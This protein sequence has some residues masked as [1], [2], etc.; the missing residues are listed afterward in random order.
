MVYW[1]RLGSHPATILFKYLGQSLETLW[2]LF[3]DRPRAVFV[4][5]PPV[6]AV[7]PV[8][9]YCRLMNVPFVIDAHS[10]AYLNR[11]WRRFQWLQRAMSRAAATTIVTNDV[12][13]DRLRQ[14]GVDVTLV[15]DVPVVFPA[16]P[17]YALTPDF[18]VAVV[19]SF[20]YDEPIEEILEAARELPDVR[21]YMTGNPRALD[22]ALRP[23]L[24][25]NVTLTGFLSTEQY[26][27]LL[28][29]ADVVVTLTTLDHTMLRGAYEAI[30]QGTPVVISDWNILRDSFPQGA[31]HVQNTR[32][33]IRAAIEDVRRDYPRHAEA[34]AGRPPRAETPDVEGH[35]DPP[36]CQR[37]AGGHCGTPAGLN[38]PPAMRSWTKFFLA[39][40]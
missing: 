2:L 24:P 31:S 4:M 13:A 23:R 27:A 3:R 7:L 19:C 5:A 16:A 38:T 9:L 17:P 22:P 10:G 14:D 26:G 11:R 36:S 18:S 28:R 39:G 20:N 25:A 12:L 21:F 29:D 6:I 34:A 40:E 32:Q 1:R 35:P 30:Y 37:A 33:A 8:F 15:R